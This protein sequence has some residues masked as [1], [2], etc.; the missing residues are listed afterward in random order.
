MGSDCISSWSLLIF[1]L[2]RALVSMW[3]F[4]WPCLC[5]FFFFSVILT[6]LRPSQHYY[7]YIE[8]FLWRAWE[9]MVNQLS[10]CRKRKMP[11]K[12]IIHSHNFSTRSS[13]IRVL[14]IL[15]HLYHPSASPPPHPHIHNR[16]SRPIFSCTFLVSSHNV[17]LFNWQWHVY[18]CIQG[19]YVRLALMPN[20]WYPLEITLLL[21][22]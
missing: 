7:I 22:L 11:P 14:F 18:L 20:I 3:I 15:K 8:P 12:S 19:P 4:L 6:I 2:C 9:G 1:L 13:P 17:C 21:L 10:E 16:D 5:F